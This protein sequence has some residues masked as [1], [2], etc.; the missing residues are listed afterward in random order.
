M[1][2]SSCLPVILATAPPS[3]KLRRRI[4]RWREDLRGLKWGRMLS[5]SSGKEGKDS[6][7]S[8]RVL[9]VTVETVLLIR[10]AAGR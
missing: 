9:L 5:W 2:S 10:L 4:W 1:N 3:A 8:S 6:R 7:F